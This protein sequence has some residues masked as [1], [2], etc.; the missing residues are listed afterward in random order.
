[1]PFAPSVKAE[2]VLP[3][4]IALAENKVIFYP[5]NLA[6]DTNNCAAKNPC[7]SWACQRYQAASG[8]RNG[9]AWCRVPL[10]IILLESNLMTTNAEKCS[11]GVQQK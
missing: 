3:V 6:M 8:R 10:D 1:M 4:V 7:V 9:R 11:F 2:L 5:D